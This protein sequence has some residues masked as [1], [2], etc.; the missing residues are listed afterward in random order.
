LISDQLTYLFTIYVMAV[1][2]ASDVPITSNHGIKIDCIV[3]DYLSSKE[4]SA[5]I[6]ITIFHNLGS[7][8]KNQTTNIRRG[9]SLFFSG[10]I[11]LVNGKLYLELHNFS[12]L[13]GQHKHSHNN[14]LPWSNAT[15]PEYSTSQNNAHLIHQE[16]KMPESTKRKPQKPFQPNKILKLADIA[17]NALPTKAMVKTRKMTKPM[18]ISMINPTTT[19]HLKVNTQR[20][21]RQ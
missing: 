2:T 10:E 8:L 14:F 1:G 4:K 17:T 16:L 20:M 6:P 11:T 12:F 21:M 15:T 13:K 3:N 5:Q 19:T 7:R 18:K 9:S